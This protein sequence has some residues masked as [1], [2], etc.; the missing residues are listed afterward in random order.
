MSKIV[1]C[2]DVVSMVIDEASN[3]FSPL[4]KINEENYK[5]LRQ[6]C[7]FIDGLAK[8]FD[9]ESYEVEVDEIKMTIS[10]KMECADV[11]IESKSHKFLELSKRAISVG[12]SSVSDEMMAVEFVFPSVWDKA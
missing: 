8:E 9:G 1:T 4:W 7:S 3:Q 6:Y 2:F 10:I 12:F 11:T 5:I